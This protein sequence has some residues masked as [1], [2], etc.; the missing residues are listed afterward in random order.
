MAVVAC[1]VQ[2]AVIVAT[3]PGSGKGAATGLKVFADKAN[4]EHEYKL[5]YITNREVFLFR[6]AGC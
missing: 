4:P 5:E 2:Q 6:L 3:V 1:V